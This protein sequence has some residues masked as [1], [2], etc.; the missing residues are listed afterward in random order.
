MDFPFG[1][2]FGFGLLALL[3]IA[4]WIWALV[5]AIRVPDDSLYKSGNKLIWVI[6]IVITGWIGAL[7]YLVAG[8]PD[9]GAN[10]A[11]ASWGSRGGSAARGTPP[12]PPP[13]PPV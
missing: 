4:F 6:V 8:R 13:P 12:P 1:F 3:G 2:F 11:I 10:A 5:D 9:G 7:I